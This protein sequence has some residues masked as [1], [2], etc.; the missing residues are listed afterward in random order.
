MLFIYVIK[1]IQTYNNYSI[2]GL[3]NTFNNLYDNLIYNTFKKYMNILYVCD[4][5]L[6]V[7]VCSVIVV[8]E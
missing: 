4:I 5:Y 1:C 7:K 3:Y 6:N 2:M 8:N